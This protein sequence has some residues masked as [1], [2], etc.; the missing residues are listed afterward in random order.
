[1][2]QKEVVDRMAAAPG[3][4]DYGRLSVMLQWRYAIESVLDVPP[5]AFD[6]P[7]RVDSAVVRM[8][9]LPAAATRSTRRCCGELVTVAFS[10]RRKL[11]RHTLGRWLEARGA[12][13]TFD[14][15]RRAEEVP[16]RNTSRLPAPSARGSAATAHGESVLKTRPARGPRRLRASATSPCRTRCSSAACSRRSCCSP[17]SSRRP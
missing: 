17:P 2:L 3:S 14:V 4:K 8:Q 16:V 5:E 11:L 13:A 15:Q 9:P 1:M 7:P 6:P 10:Q 12:T